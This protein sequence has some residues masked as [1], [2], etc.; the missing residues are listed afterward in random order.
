MVRSLTLIQTIVLTCIA[1]VSLK[2]QSSDLQ[3]TLDQVKVYNDQGLMVKADSVLEIAGAMIDS[4]T[5]PEDLFRFKFDYGHSLIS[6]WKLSEAEPVFKEALDLSYQMSDTSKIVAAL[7]GMATLKN[8]KGEVFEAIQLQEMAKTMPPK[9]SVTYYSLMS[10]LGIAYNDIQQYDKSLA[11]Y[12]SAKRYFKKEG[13]YLNL[14]LIENN[15]GELYRERFEDFDLAQKHYEEAIRLNKLISNQSHLSMN[16]H[17][18][19]LNHLKIDQP[20]SALH[21]ILRAI[22]LREQ[23]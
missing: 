17:N 23:A 20:D 18:L 2:A 10:N 4:D 6:K 15:L 16:Y 5:S 22:H 8:F 14:A 21:Y 7:S 11:H 1:A 12:L 9:D 3:S 13:V 19:A